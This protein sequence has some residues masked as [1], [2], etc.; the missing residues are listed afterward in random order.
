MNERT[1]RQ[2]FWQILSAVEYCHNRNIVHRDL[3]VSE[4]ELPPREQVVCVSLGIDLSL[5]C[6]HIC[7]Y[8]YVHIL[9]MCAT[10][11]TCIIAYTQTHSQHIEFNHASRW[12]A[13]VLELCEKP[14][15]RTA[16]ARTFRVPPPPKRAGHGH[17]GRS[18]VRFLPSIPNHDLYHIGLHE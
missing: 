1:A 17:K 13:S 6:L 8:T 14:C 4:N 12:R 16:R 15:V 9:C 5:H 7:T 2:K 11:T 3:K 18:A 10:V